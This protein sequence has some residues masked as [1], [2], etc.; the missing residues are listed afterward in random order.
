MGLGGLGPDG[1]TGPLGSIPKFKFLI[2][3]GF[4]IGGLSPDGGTEPLGSV[5]KCNGGRL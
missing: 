4:R 5:T 3:G 1:G 2:S